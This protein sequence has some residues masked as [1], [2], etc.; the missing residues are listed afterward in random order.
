MCVCVCVFVCIYIYINKSRAIVLCLSVQRCTLHCGDLLQVL[1]SRFH[2]RHN[3]KAIQHVQMMQMM[4]INSRM[5]SHSR[6]C[7][8]LY[9]PRSIRHEQGV[10]DQHTC[11]PAYSLA[12]C[13]INFANQKLVASGN[14]DPCTR[15]ARSFLE[16]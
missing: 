1:S 5:C 11:C 15:L 13:K 10:V 12:N 6:S 8:V 3:L 4:Q 14:R 9:C 2:K 7:I 16:D